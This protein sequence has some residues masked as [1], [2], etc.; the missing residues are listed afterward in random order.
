[1]Q[2]AVDENCSGLLWQVLDWSEP[3]INFYRKYNADIKGEWLNCSLEVDQ[4]KSV[5]AKK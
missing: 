4:L 2:H 3:A 1:M 5:L